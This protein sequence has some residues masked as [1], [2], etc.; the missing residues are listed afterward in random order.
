MPVP[1]KT[2]LAGLIFALCIGVFAGT[3]SPAAQA[4]ASQ[5]NTEQP[6]NKKHSVKIKNTTQRST[7]E[8]SKAERDRRMY[9]E[10][11]G[12]PNAGACLGYTHR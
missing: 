5:P 1:T 9:R 2:N 4:A 6:I 11:K 10:C 8:E 3:A 7:S 12:R